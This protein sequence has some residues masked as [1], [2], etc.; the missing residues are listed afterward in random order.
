[1]TPR[2]RLALSAALTFAMFSSACEPEER[3]FER[4]TNLEVLE[5]LTMEERREELRAS[6]EDDDVFAEEAPR[7]VFKDGNSGVEVIT[8]ERS[9]RVDP[10]PSRNARDPLLDALD[11]LDARDAEARRVAEWKENNPPT[12]TLSLIH[13]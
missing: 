8:V 1:M 3:P 2:R 5:P 11:A 4:P 10:P 6:E 9:V 13:I 7:Q 12:V